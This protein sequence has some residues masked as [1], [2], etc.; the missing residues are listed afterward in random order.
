M[1][2]NSVVDVQQKANFISQNVNRPTQAP[3]VAQQ[4]PQV[5][6]QQIQALADDLKN[7]RFEMN[8]QMKFVRSLE[9]LRIHIPPC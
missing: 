3:Q 5:Q 4:V 8:N 2:R 6:P 1:F 9:P 7:F